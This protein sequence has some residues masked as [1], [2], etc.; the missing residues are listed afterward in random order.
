MKI[1]QSYIKNL[2]QRSAVRAFSMGH[3]QL[4]V[5]HVIATLLAS[6]EVRSAIDSKKAIL[7]SNLDARPEHDRSSPLVKVAIANI[8]EDLV[9]YE[10]R[11]RA[12]DELYLKRDRGFSVSVSKRLENFI[13]CFIRCNLSSS[14]RVENLLRS[15]LNDDSRVF[16]FWAGD[17]TFSSAFMSEMSR[18]AVALSEQKQSDDGEHT[19]ENALS[20]LVSLSDKALAGKILPA[21][22]RSAEVGAVLDGLRMFKKANPLLLGEAGVGKTAIAEEVARLVA[23]AKTKIGHG[24]EGVFVEG[25]FVDARLVNKTVYSLSLNDLSQGTRYRGDLEERLSVIKKFLEDRD[26]VILFVDEI[27]LLKKGETNDLIAQSLK[28]L[29]ARSGISLIGSTTVSEYREY[30]ESDEAFTRRFHTITIEEPSEKDATEILWRS[31]RYYE[32]HHDV[33]VTWLAVQACVRLSKEFVPH[34][35][36][37]DKAFD[38][39]DLV[40]SKKS[41]ED[42]KRAVAKTDEGVSIPTDTAVTI[43]LVSEYDVIEA[44]SEKLGISEEKV[45]RRYNPALRSKEAVVSARTSAS[46]S[47]N[48]QEKINGVVNPATISEESSSLVDDVPPIAA[49]HSG[50]ESLFSEAGLSSVDYEGLLESLKKSVIGQDDALQ[51]VSDTLEASS[52]RVFNKR[53]VEASFFFV[54]PSGVGKTQV[55]KTLA[56]FTGRK[57][58]RFDMSEYQQESSVNNLIGSSKG[59][60]G[61]GEGGQLVNDIRRHPDAIVLF[62]EIEKAH[63][64]VLDIFLQLLD[65]GSLSDSSGKRAD[66]KQS[67][68]IFTSN[69]GAS[70]VESYVSRQA[71]APGSHDLRSWYV[72]HY[73]KT[74]KE[75]LRPEFVARIHEVVPFT[76]ISLENMAKIS[77]NYLRDLKAELLKHRINLSWESSAVDFCA[78]EAKSSGSGA[79]S[80]EGLFS[81]QVVLLISRAS[82]SQWAKQSLQERGTIEVR[83]KLNESQ[84]LEA[85]DGRVNAV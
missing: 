48:S 77:L 66:F 58:L 44:V 83:L 62:D 20:F 81:K 15:V 69:L 2:L 31:S 54:G 57:L 71:F 10:L 42:K 22:G 60:V 23:L 84:A 32:N 59:Y 80:L 70:S 24:E 50:T 51:T 67:V 34:R 6:P 35:Q 7:L 73:Q 27:H 9:D 52:L 41:N 26:D 74:L 16:L 82:R 55:A 28:P 38:F 18:R 5:E 12:T 36:L 61:Y 40:C 17:S 33:I 3:S 65:E 37:P 14:S 75:S 30:L 1:S 72:S 79:R 29:L 45:R 13:D 43:S 46:E 21:V 78:R 53:G 56:E 64:R 4:D 68:V 39:L 63:P 8:L 76:D 25:I 19:K 47:L 85:A 49:A 11:S